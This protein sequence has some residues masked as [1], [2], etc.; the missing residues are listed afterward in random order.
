[1]EWLEQ[2][3]CNIAQHPRYI[4]YAAIVFDV[5]AV[6]FVILSSLQKGPLGSRFSGKRAADGSGHSGPR[7][8]HEPDNV[9][10]RRRNFAILA[11]L[12]L[13]IGAGFHIAASEMQCAPD[14][15]SCR[16]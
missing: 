5:V 3:W 10:R 6:C 11:I 13:V 15:T 2:I 4:M 12:C 1:M 9:V 14:L 7:P 16:P 8:G